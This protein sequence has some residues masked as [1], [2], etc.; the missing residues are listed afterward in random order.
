MFRTTLM[1]FSQGKL[2]DGSLSTAQKVC[3]LFL[4]V[5]VPY[6]SARATAGAKRA[7]I[8]VERARFHH[9]AVSPMG[10]HRLVS[11]GSQPRSNK[12]LAT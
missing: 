2:F 1:F 5:V 8:A 11:A 6:L 9:T 3:Q 4:A 7:S 10:S 12:N